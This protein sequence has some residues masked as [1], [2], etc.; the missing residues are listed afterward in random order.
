MFFGDDRDRSAEKWN[1]GQAMYEVAKCATNT[2]RN[3]RYQSIDE[4]INVWNIAKNKSLIFNT[5][6]HTGKSCSEIDGCCG[7]ANAAFLITY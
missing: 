6:I 7:L 3:K 2:K 5:V 4:F 1:A